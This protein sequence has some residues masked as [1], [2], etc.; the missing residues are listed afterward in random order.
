M[1]KY[2][3][4]EFNE[5]LKEL[6][7]IAYFSG[8]HLIETN[9]DSSDLLKT[10]NGYEVKSKTKGDHFHDGQMV[11]YCFSFKSPGGEKT[12]IYTDMCLMVGWNIGYDVEIN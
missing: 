7:E 1:I 2:T 10:L 12:K 8:W 3:S 11:E 5:L 4:D 6:D 9:K